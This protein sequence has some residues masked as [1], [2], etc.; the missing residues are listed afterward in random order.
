MATEKQLKYWER[1]RGN[2]NNLG[3]HWKV[4]DTSNLKINNTSFKKGH[5]PFPLNGEKHWNW[6]GGLS[7]KPYTTDWTIT[8][9]KSIR[10]RDHYIC[11]MCKLPQGEEALHVHHIDYNKTNCNPDNL[12]SLHRGCHVKT[13]TNRD[14][15]TNYFL[16]I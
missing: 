7:F 16:K 4:K 15:W 6:Q 14:Y 13:N 10:E 2:K 5:K 11:S 1:L 12:I 8:L 9:R 3:K